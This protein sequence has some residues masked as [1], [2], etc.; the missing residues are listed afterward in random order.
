MSQHKKKLKTQ[1]RISRSNKATPNKIVYT[2]AK[3]SKKSRSEKNSVDKDSSNFVSV[4]DSILDKNSVPKIEE[5]ED[6][7]TYQIP[8]RTAEQDRLAFEARRPTLSPTKNGGFAKAEPEYQSDEEK[9][10]M[11]PDSGTFVKTNTQQSG[12]ILHTANNQSFESK[13]VQVFPTPSKYQLTH[14][15]SKCNTEDYTSLTD[16]EAMTHMVMHIGYLNKQEKKFFKDLSFDMINFDE[17]EGVFKKI[18]NAV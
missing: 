13:T 15:I 9:I 1:E 5:Q 2:S 18:E 12:S 10:S 16:S 7:H 4:E 14:D 3:K 11:S 17:A 8:P 6:F